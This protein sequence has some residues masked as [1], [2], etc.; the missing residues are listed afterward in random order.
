M[1]LDCARVAARPA[2]EATRF[3]DDLGLRLAYVTAKQIFHIDFSEICKVEMTCL[4]CGA[5]IVFPVC[6]EK[7]QEYPPASY[8]CLGCHSAFWSSANDEGYICIY[9][10]FEGLAHWQTI[11]GQNFSLSFSLDSN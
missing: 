4:N 9:R 11:K 8:S 5:A 3:L 2:D 6:R 7:G 10:L 1:A